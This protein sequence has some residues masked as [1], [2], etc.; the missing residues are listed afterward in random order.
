M[1]ILASDNFTRANE[2]PLN[3]TNWTVVT[4]S[5]NLQI[6]NNL[7]EPTALSTL[8]RELWTNATWPNDQYS[9]VTVN[10]FTNGNTTNIVF[11]F[12]RSSTTTAGNNYALKIIG[13]AAGNPTWAITGSGG[14]ILTSGTLAAAVSSGDVFS[15]N[16]VGTT[17]TAYKNGVSF[18]T[19]TNASF[20]SG[21]PGMGLEDV[22][23]LSNVD[24]SLWA[25]GSVV[26]TANP[27]ASPNGGSFSSA[28]TV[29][30]SCATVNSTIY[31]TTNGSTP[32]VGVSP[33][34]PSGGTI[35]ISS[36]VTLKM[37]AMSNGAFDTHS[38][39]VDAVF[40]ISSGGGQGNQPM[41]NVI[42]DLDSDGFPILELQTG[43]DA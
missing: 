7:C 21:T 11:I 43:T 22:V 29:T 14:A 16:I 36:S 41:Q 35:S 5:G 18:G 26:T 19:V 6:V 40:T 10:N 4:G 38:S 37:I 32:V 25:G 34:V 3:A 30:L 33:S 31:Y 8:C 2:N 13:A 1:P 27:T 12:V 17:L 15:L 39:E 28:Q 23:V 24:A 9:S 20:A 42:F